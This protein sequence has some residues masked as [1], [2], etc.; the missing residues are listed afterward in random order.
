[1]PSVGQTATN[2]AKHPQG[3]ASTFCWQSPAR[4]ACTTAC[5]RHHATQSHLERSWLA[6]TTAGAAAC[7]P[8]P[9]E[10]RCHARIRW[11]FEPALGSAAP[12]RRIAMPARSISRANPACKDI[13]RGVSLRVVALGRATK[14]LYYLPW[15]RASRACASCRG[16]MPEP[17][18]RRPILLNASLQAAPSGAHT[19]PRCARP[20]LARAPAR[21]LPPACSPLPSALLFYFRRGSAQ[22]LLPRA[23][24]VWCCLRCRK[25]CRERGRT[26]IGADGRTRGHLCG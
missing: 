5:S 1:M 9:W 21:P 19:R 11:Y 4:Q 6:D 15:R 16:G 8:N 12:R 13:V 18:A 22:E 10:V 20:W 25:A 7:V 17:C 26:R 14:C 2:E 23:L 3:D 24:W